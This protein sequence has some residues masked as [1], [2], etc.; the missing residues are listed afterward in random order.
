[1]AQYGT[2]IT[3][4]GLA[5]ITNAQITQDTVDLLHIALGDGD[6]AYYV[7]SQS[8]TALKNEVWRGV[9]ADMKV[10]ETNPNR[11]T[12]SAYLP[13]NVG[14]FTIREV[15]LFDTENNLIALSLYPEQYKPQLAEGVSED[16]LLHFEIETANA[17]VITLAVDPTV[18]VASRKYVD[19]K[20]G[21]NADDI[22]AVDEKVDTHLAKSVTRK[23]SNQKPSSNDDEIQG[24]KQG[25]VWIHENYVDEED[26]EYEAY[27]CLDNKTGQ[28][29]WKKY[30]G[31]TPS[32]IY[33]LEWNQTL[34]T[35]QRLDDAVSMVAITQGQNDFDNV[36]PWSEMKRCN[37]DDSG[38]VLAY[39]G[40]PTYK[41][42]GSN[43]QVMVQIPKF[44]YKSVLI[45]VGEKKKYRWWIADNELEGFKLHPAFVRNGV[46]KDFIYI[47][48][49]EGYENSGKLH[50][51][52]G[53]M[54]TVNKTIVEFRNLAQARGS[55]WF[56][57]DFL[58]ICAIQ[59][60]Y[61]IEY[62][63][64]DSQTKIGQGITG[65]SAYHQ[66]GETAQHG[67]K[68]FGD[69]NDATV[70]M[71]YRG[72]ENLYGN[73]WKWV[74]GINFLDRQVYVAD[75]S[76]ESD[77]F[78]GHYENLGIVLPNANGFVK[79]IHHI[80]IFDYGFLSSDPTG[81]ST[82][83]IVDQQYTNYTGARVAR[84]GG[85]RNVRSGAGTFYWSFSDPSSDSFAEVGA[86]LLCVP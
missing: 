71:S 25:D 53:V 48:A 19:E 65:D 75:H 76:F 73:Y 37:L 28:A 14:G 31:K 16:V 39:Y 58:A 35:Y 74:D 47:G 22:A 36:Y 10:S 17:S 32:K 7:P 82:S 15:G 64:F 55:K 56:Q 67:N 51:I 34:D 45:S 21:K 61:L 84:F 49:Y 54:P 63:H 8:Q 85:D 81:S 68:S 3:N 86:R 9:I 79:D 62:A 70:A 40:D 13:S 33:G 4:I 26:Y 24:F 29:K 83:Y 57:Q 66:T 46:E 38:N 69:P 23:V 77:K 18:I 50:S 1:M 11:I 30:V 72:I 60:L 43:G 20:V 42:D 52:A 78:D 2:I 5:K 6:G 59:L 12:V 80:Q 41:D 44:W 27:I